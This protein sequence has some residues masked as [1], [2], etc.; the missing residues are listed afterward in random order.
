MDRINR[1][2][3]EKKEV[4]SFKQS[5]DEIFTDIK[6]LQKESG[7]LFS[8]KIDSVIFIWSGEMKRGPNDAWIRTNLS[9]EENLKLYIQK[10]GIKKIPMYYFF[11]GFYSKNHFFDESNYTRNLYFQNILF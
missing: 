8:N 4:I 3:N 1:L 11:E 5:M 2:T 10:S 6:K 9:A 7:L